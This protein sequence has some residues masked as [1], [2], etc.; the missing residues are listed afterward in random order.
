MTSS[1]LIPDVEREYGAKVA[2]VEPGGAEQIPLDERHGRPLQLLWTWA[3][4]NLEFATV[5]VGVLGVLVF[6]LSFW[7]AA[8]AILIG[9]AG[10]AL[11]QGILS[12]W[13]PKS[14]L[15]QMVLGRTAFGFI[16]NLLPAGLMSLTAGIGW[17]AVNSVSGAF[18]LNVLTHI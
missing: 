7:L 8:L 14:G 1:V 12:T 18:A 9:T 4:P 5:F 15:P 10:G 3:S 11:T 2:A 17:F 6:G 16:G 13:G